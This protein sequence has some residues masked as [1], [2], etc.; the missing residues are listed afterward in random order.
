VKLY[1]SPH[2][3]WELPGQQSKAA[4]R[5]DIPSTPVA[6]CQWLQERN[7]SPEPGQP[8]GSLFSAPVAAQRAPEP[9]PINMA[10][11]AIPQKPQPSSFEASAIEEFILDRATVAEVERIFQALGCRF[12]EAR[13]AA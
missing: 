12:A 5:V 1:H 9:L 3:G 13:R 6:L 4:F 7:V 8:A 10:T 11:A 2:R